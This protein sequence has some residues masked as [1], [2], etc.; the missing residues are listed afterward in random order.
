[1][2]SD[3]L[4]CLLNG[5]PSQ[6]LSAFDRGLA[7]GDG[8]FETMRWSA[9]RFPLLPHHLSRLAQGASRLGIPLDLDALEGDIAQ[10]VPALQA[11]PS[12]VV[13][14]TVTR[15]AGGRGYLPGPDLIP[16]RLLAAY[17]LQQRAGAAQ[18]VALRLC[19][20]RLGLSP[21]LA[22]LKHLGR[23]EQVLARM[24]WRDP[25]IAEGLMLSVDGRVVEG[26]MSNLFLVKD[27]R[28]YT[29]CLRDAGVAGV[30][31]SWL[32]DTLRRRQGI[33]VQVQ[34]LRLEDVLAAD[35]VFVCNSVIGIWPV[36]SFDRQH[37]PVG[38]LTRELQV[39][40][41]ELFV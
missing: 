31:R 21:A 35:E 15:G 28:C 41:D 8:L 17:P 27:Q 26:T 25:A 36:V 10:L 24:E 37:W 16:T 3:A 18:G 39:V 13:R 38:P 23:L 20:T 32:M 30:M 6:Q 7:Y 11:L 19:D 12:A 2:S 33:E 29:P 4:V 5:V 1:M 14:L 22:G 34:D 9:G 40:V